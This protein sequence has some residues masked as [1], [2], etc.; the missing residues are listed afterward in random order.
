V[1]A[2]AAPGEPGNL[3]VVEQAGRILVLQNGKVRT[4]PFLD[5]R[6]LV[7]SGGEQGLLSV[8]FD[9]GYAKN[10]RFYV[11]YTDVHGDTRVVRYTSDGTSA[12]PGSAKLLVFVKDFASNHNGGQLQFGRT[13]SCTGGTATVAAA[14]IRST[15]AR[16]SPAHSRRSCG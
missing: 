8:A 3:Y 12:I 2:T 14:A 15:T 4:T 13:S 16:A 7:Q 9:P 5:T 1:Y 6:S 11:D 10:R